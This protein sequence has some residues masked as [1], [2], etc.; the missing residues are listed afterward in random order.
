MAR[1]T[2]QLKNGARQAFTNLFTHTLPVLF[3]SLGLFLGGIALL[4]LRIPGWSLFLGL[5]ATQLGIIL[6]I[7]SFDKIARS[8]VGP[9]NLEITSCPLC[10]QRVISIV[11]EEE[12]LCEDCQEKAIKEL[13]KEKKIKLAS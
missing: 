2:A 8:Q 7:F 9:D 3:L 6:L 11:G 5:P 10:G 4:A 1:A 12:K 13:K